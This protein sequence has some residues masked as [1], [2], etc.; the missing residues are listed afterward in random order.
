MHPAGTQQVKTK[1]TLG[2]P[3]RPCASCVNAIGSTGLVGGQALLRAAVVVW[4]LTLSGKAFRDFLGSG[5][6][7]PFQRYGDGPR[8]V[9]CDNVNVIDPCVSGPQ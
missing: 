5:V 7:F 6:E 9:R 1:R 8:R 4:P 2:K 3:R